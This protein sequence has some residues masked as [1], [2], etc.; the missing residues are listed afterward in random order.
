[1]AALAVDENEF[2][3]TVAKNTDVNPTTTIFI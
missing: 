2:K 3:R 1:M